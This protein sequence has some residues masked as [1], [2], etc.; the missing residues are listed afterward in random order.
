MKKILFCLLFLILVSKNSYSAQLTLPYGVEYFGEVKDGVPH[1]KGTAIF[2]S[3]E[4]YVGDWKYGKSHGQGVYVFPNGNSFKG[5]WKDGVYVNKSNDLDVKKKLIE[6]KNTKEKQKLENKIAEENKKKKLIAEKEK[7]EDEKLNKMLANLKPEERRAYICEKTY[8]FRKGSDK[9]SECVY[10]ILSADLEL[11]KMEVQKKLAQAQEETA[12]ANALR[13]NT[14]AYDPAIGRA[15]ERAQE[16]ETAR[17]AFEL[18]RQLNPQRY[19]PQQQNNIQLPKQQY[20][21]LNPINNRISCYTT[22]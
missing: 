20:C 15:A 19:A 1:G 17:L 13:N 7:A 11:E 3:G 6:N 8:G 4:T 22:P 2:S 21:K 18:A 12:K 5:E 10:K 16:L 9:F 14:P